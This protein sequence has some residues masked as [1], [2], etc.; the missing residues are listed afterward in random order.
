MKKH[1]VVLWIL[2]IVFMA[3]R[4]TVR[5]EYWVVLSLETCGLAIALLIKAKAP[6]KKYIF[7]SIILAVLSTVAYLG[8]E[9]NPWVLLYGLRAGIPTLLC[10]LA[11][12]SVMEKRGGYAL[13]SDKGKYPFLT[14]ILIAIVVGG[15]LA[16]VNL[17]GNEIS[18]APSFGKIFLC[19]NPAIYEEIADRAIFIAFCVWY[20][21]G[22]M[23]V[24]QIFTMYFMACVPHAAV[25]GYPLVPTLMLCAV[26]GLPFAILQKKRDIT[27]AML[28]HGIVDAVRFV[29]IGF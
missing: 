24:F 5:M 15:I 26:F 4:L 14:T 16:A 27:C 12:F 18:F 25:H 8:Y 3:F 9:S 13:L 21:D 19:L 7:I 10:G 6:S 28:S 29:L 17:I 23:N 11:V 22:K 20:A 2:F 1:D